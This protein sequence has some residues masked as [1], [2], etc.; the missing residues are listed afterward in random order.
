MT[1]SALKVALGLW[2]CA[3]QLGCSGPDYDPP[4]LITGF[5]VLAV[6]AEPPY[7]ALAPSQLSAFVLKSA[8]EQSLC[9]AWALCPFAWENEG[10]Y[11]CLDPRLQV[12][13]GNDAEASMSLFELFD[14]FDDLPKVLEEKGLN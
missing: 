6:R 8:P 12:D 1:T 13:L 3:L 10:N 14:V 2:M 9:Y 4:T 5:R 7:V 11:E